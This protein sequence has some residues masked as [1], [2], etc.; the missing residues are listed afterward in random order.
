MASTADLCIPNIGPRQRRL[1]LIS[2]LVMAALAALAAAALLATGTSRAWRVLLIVPIGAAAVG[3]FQVQ[4]KTCV[5]LAA[6]GLRNLDAGDE[7]ISDERQ[8]AR[9]R[10]QSRGVYMKALVATLA[11]TGILLFL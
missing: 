8:L 10:A 2:G 5:A 1:R 3:L 7:T 6:R 4:A 11:L 9:V